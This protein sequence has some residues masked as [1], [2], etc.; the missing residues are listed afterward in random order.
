MEEQDLITESWNYITYWLDNETDEYVD[1]KSLA[2]GTSE[3]ILRKFQ[4]ELSIDLPADFCNSYLL[5]NGFEK[6]TGLVHGGDLLSL[7]KIKKIYFE[8]IRNKQGVEWDSD[9]LPCVEFGKDE[10]LCLNL[11]DKR[12]YWAEMN[13]NEKNIHSY[14]TYNS[15]SDFLSG[16]ATDLKEGNGSMGE[17]L[18]K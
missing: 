3:E 4:A 7:T 10:F 18:G 5:H 8:L 14:K 13:E 6:R 17:M 15:F 16:L 9:M 12:I 11:A 1:S 2:D